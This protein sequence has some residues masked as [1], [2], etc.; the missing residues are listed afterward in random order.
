MVSH[1]FSHLSCLSLSEN[2]MPEFQTAPILLWPMHQH[3]QLIRVVVRERSLKRAVATYLSSFY[4]GSSSGTRSEQGRRPGSRAWKWQS[5]VGLCWNP[6]H[7][8]VRKREDN[9]S[10]P[11][12][13]ANQVRTLNTSFK[14]NVL[15]W[16]HSEW[17]TVLGLQCFSFRCVNVSCWDSLSYLCCKIHVESIS[18]LQG[19][20]SPKQKN[21]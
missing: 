1:L 11:F 4:Q 12:L 18:V 19:N 9:L 21:K 5:R 6:K 8:R 13:Y 7:R 15:P 20:W 14:K 10:V 2:R 3:S 16:K 17:V